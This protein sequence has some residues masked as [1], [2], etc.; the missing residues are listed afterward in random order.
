MSFDPNALPVPDV[1]LK[2]LKCS[3]NLAGLPEHRCPECG[4]AFTMEDRIPKGD[5]PVVIFNSKEVPCDAKVVELLNRVH[6]PYMEVLRPGETMMGLGGST[7]PGGRLA[8]PRGSYWEV[9]DLLRRQALGEPLPEPQD[10]S[11]PD[12]R[13]EGCGEENPSG[14]EIC[15]NCEKQRPDG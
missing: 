7:R 6:I 8:V 1:G 11:G 12:W 2:C 15:W 9:I 3:Y 10:R 5:F 4:T 14:F 13:C